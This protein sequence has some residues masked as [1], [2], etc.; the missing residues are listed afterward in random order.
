MVNVSLSGADP[1]LA[2]PVPVLYARYN[3]EYASWKIGVFC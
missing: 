3:V 2:A 1:I